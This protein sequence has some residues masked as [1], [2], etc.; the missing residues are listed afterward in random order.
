MIDLRELAK[1]QYCDNSIRIVCTDGQIIEGE[2]GE[3]DDEEESGLGEP[4]ITVYLESGGW[5]GIAISEIESINEIKT[6]DSY[7]PMYATV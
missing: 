3:V 2:A 1:Y 7:S 6:A 4:G 5:V